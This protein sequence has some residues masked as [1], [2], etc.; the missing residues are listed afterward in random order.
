M[1][2]LMAEAQVDPECLNR[3]KDLVRNV[4]IDRFRRAAQND[5]FILLESSK[6]DRD[7]YDHWMALILV[8]GKALRITFKV[9]FNIKASKLN[10]IKTIF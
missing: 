3:M 7:V 6:T 2:V 10:N 1:E 5:D 4:S 8:S 9:H